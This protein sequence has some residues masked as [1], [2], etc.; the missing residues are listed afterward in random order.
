M[1]ANQSTISQLLARSKSLAMFKAN[2]EDAGQSD[3]SHQQVSG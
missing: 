2:Q 3:Q 1:K